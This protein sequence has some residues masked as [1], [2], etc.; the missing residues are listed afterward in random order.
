M[1]LESKLREAMLGGA[2]TTGEIIDLE[3][4]KKKTWKPKII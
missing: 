3:E 4:F 1:E 2:S